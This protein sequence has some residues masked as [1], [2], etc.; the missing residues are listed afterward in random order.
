MS[1]PK[2]LKDPKTTVA[3]D[4]TT[5]CNFV[6]ELEDSGEYGDAARLMGDWWRG[7]GVRPEVDNLPTGKKASV[8]SRVGSLSGWLGSMQQ[9]PDSQE[10]AKDLISE[11]ANLFESINDHPN[12][13]EAR[14]D[15]A[16]CYWREGAFAEAGVIL[17]DVLE[18]GFEFSPEL[19]GKI[20]L[21]SVNVEISTRH[22]GKA[23]SLIGQAAPLIEDTGNNLLRGK[24]YFHRALI[25]RAQGEDENNPAHFISA[26]KDYE[27]ASVYY[28]KAKHDRY[29]A[30]VENNTGNVYRLLQ[31]YEN[32]HLHLDNALRMYVKLKDRGRAALVYDNKARAFITQGNLSDAELTAL[33]SVNMLREGGEQAT[34]AE[35]LT[36]LGVVLSRGGNFTEAIHTFVQAREA[37][38]TVGDMESAGNAVLTQIEELQADLSP[39]VFSALYLEADELLKNSPKPSTVNR[40]QKIA[41]RQIEMGHVQAEVSTDSEKMAKL[42]K[43]ADKLDSLFEGE[44]A[45]PVFNWE[46]FS[47][48]EAVRTYE[49]E[50]ILK[51]LTESKGRVT[52]A[53]QMLGLS[54]QNL[55]LI[56]HQRHK[57]L[58][59]NCVQR[60]P[61]SKPQLKTH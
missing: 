12:W 39:A 3:S 4:I 5:I 15:L 46:N 57:E 31:D 11:A 59:K 60:K 17:Q 41:K 20:L 55:S 47:L 58:K 29:V 21:R 30:M 23:M 54:H 13:A 44:A 2:M 26:V 1:I 34:L 42:L 8:L 14:S 16:V 40:L 53:A 27:H 36:T 50:I 24:L 35:S 56:L 51:A 45:E 43:Y 28:T 22:Y 25:L 48:P 9:M 52:R 19:Q 61:R 32:A 33:A 38:L 49:G 37:A 18:S 7:V 10:K 6:K